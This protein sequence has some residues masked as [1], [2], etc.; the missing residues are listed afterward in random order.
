[1]PIAGKTKLVVEVTVASC[2]I[3]SKTKYSV[4][5]AQNSGRTSAKKS[6]VISLALAVQ[7]AP[8]TGK[9]NLVAQVVVASCATY[10]TAP[11][12]L[13]TGSHSYLL[14]FFA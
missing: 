7:I 1:M 2:A 5:Q 9:T 12:S 10:I 8:L 3:R 6:N 4:Q 11:T 13:V 14:D